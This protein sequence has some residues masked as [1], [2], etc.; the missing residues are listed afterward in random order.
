MFKSFFYLLSLSTSALATPVVNMEKRV[1]HY[2]EAIEYNPG[3]GACGGLN[4]PGDFVVALNAAKFD[5]DHGGNCD[6]VVEITNVKK[7]NVATAKLV[8]ECPG[9]SQGSLDMS[10]ALFSKLNDGDLDAGVFNITWH[11]QS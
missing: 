4:G 9:C 8:D 10:P 3:F 1:E 5:E 6:Q 2:G 11:F 7:G